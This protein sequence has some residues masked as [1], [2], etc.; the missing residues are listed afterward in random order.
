MKRLQ[1]SA[2][3][4][5]HNHG[6][7][8][9][10]VVQDLASQTRPPDEILVVDDASTDDSRQR[11]ARL[12]RRIPGLRWVAERERGGCNAAVNR[13]AGLAR[14]D[15]LFLVAADDRVLPGFLER[16]LPLLEAH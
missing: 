14:G 7:F 16:A 11:L 2:V 3:I 6:A 13:G 15:A 5:N 1:L 10:D 8:L 12:E 9:E 4:P